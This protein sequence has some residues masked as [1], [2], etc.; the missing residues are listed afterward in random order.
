MTEK[1]FLSLEISH[2]DFH[3]VERIA[4]QSEMTTKNFCKA[5][6]IQTGVHLDRLRSGVKKFTRAQKIAIYLFDALYEHTP[7]FCF[8]AMQRTRSYWKGWS[9][10][11]GEI[12]EEYEKFNFNL[13]GIPISMG[14]YMDGVKDH[15]ETRKRKEVK[16]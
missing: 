7:M 3:T 8:A 10:A 5:I 9:D 13:D 1:Q 6:G 2:I 12:P 4:A 11:G 14:T 16:E 15:T